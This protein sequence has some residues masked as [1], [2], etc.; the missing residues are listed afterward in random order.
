MKK[1]IILLIVLVFVLIFFAEG[2]AA[3]LQKSVVPAAAK[4]VLHFDMQK[5]TTSR[6]H[7]A[8]KN[9]EIMDK[10]KEKNAKISKSFGIDLLNDIKSVTV[11]GLGV[12]EKDVVVCVHGNFTE[13]QLI[14]QIKKKETPKEISYLQYTIYSGGHDEFLSF[15]K[16][17][18]A[19]IGQG[20]KA[21]E[22]A[23]DVVAGNKQ[24]ISASPLKSELNKAPSDAFLTAVVENISAL[25][26]K[27]KPVILTK[28]GR[29]LFTLAEKQENVAFDLNV[30]TLTPEDAKNM[31]QILR[32]LIA[33]ANMQKEDI[34]ADIKLPEDLLIQTEGNTVRMGF[35]YPVDYI[36][37]LVSK[38]AKFSHFVF[39]DHFSSLI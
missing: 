29:A 4:W 28:M 26:K 16:E 36:I 15:P 17:G 11:Y 3:P 13:D 1:T 9:L 19:I 7:T 27:A 2:L 5:Y 33:M 23:L 32:G 8:F 21:I 22:T 30:S 10:L 6:L 24:D 31:E 12:E 38:R 14:N 35:T 25:T 18:F 34:P 37:E 39:K 20:E